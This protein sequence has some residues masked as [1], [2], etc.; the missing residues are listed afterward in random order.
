MGND[1]WLQDMIKEAGI[2]FANGV[3]MSEKMYKGMKDVL[4]VVGVVFIVY[5]CC[6]GFVL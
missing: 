4:I 3:E 2:S 5:G 1:T 6:G